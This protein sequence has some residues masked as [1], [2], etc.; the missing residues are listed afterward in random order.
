MRKNAPQT[1]VCAGIALLLVSGEGCSRAF[2]QADNQPLGGPGQLHLAQYTRP[3][4]EQGPPVEMN[5]GRAGAAAGA[6]YSGPPMETN[7][8]ADNSAPPA[9]P[10]TANRPDI[11]PL[12]SPPPGGYPASS[13]VGP[14]SQSVGI[15]PQSQEGY[16]S[17]LNSPPPSPPPGSAFGQDVTSLPNDPASAPTFGPTLPLPGQPPIA[18]PDGGGQ[19]PLVEDGTAVD[20]GV[21][22]RFKWR[23]RECEGKLWVD[24]DNYLSWTTARDMAIALGI[25]AVLANTPLDQHF[26]N[27]FQNNVR[28]SGTDHFSNSIAFLG[29]GQYMIPAALGLTAAGTLIGDNWVGNT[30]G[31]FGSQ[32]C[33]A[34]LIGAP[35]LLLCQYGLGASR[36]ATT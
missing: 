16:L 2:T 10:N 6:N 17:T 25:A 31:D 9:Y 8:Q 22:E 30:T 14:L 1:L 21:V 11:P 32:T 27:W 13:P 36:P 28:T 24:V 29:K 35:S 23:F 19:N 3:Q 26:Q 33:R 18:Q 34:Y 15:V 12:P 4:G 5:P 7:L 20:F